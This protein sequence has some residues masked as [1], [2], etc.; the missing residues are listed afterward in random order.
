[1]FIQKISTYF[2]DIK[3]HDTIMSCLKQ[4]AITHDSFITFKKQIL[5]MKINSTI[6]TTTTTTGLISGGR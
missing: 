4:C 3:V 2:T 6:I 1:L 5:L